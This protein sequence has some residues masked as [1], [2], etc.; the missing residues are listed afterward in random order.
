MKIKKSLLFLSL[1]LTT[2]I[3]V[4]ISC[5][6][7]TSAG[8]GAVPPGKSELKIM[9]TDDPSV[10]FDSIFLDIQRVEVKEENIGI[11]FQ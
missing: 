4:F 11:R 1:F 2:M 7:E 5:K 10:I 9:M 6:K 3:L 8:P